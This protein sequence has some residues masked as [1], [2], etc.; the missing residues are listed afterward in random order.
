MIVK[1]GWWFEDRRL[2]PYDVDD[3][4]LLY[5]WDVPFPFLFPFPDDHY[6]ETYLKVCEGDQE[7]CRA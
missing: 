3:A 2:S 4:A 1:G 6:Q 7:F 5:A